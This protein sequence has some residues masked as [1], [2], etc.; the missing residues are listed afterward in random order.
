MNYEFTEENNYEDFASGRVLYNQKGT[1]SFPARLIS[2]IFLRSME[3]LKKQGI[4]G[5]YSIYDP[6]CGGA[7]GL[8][9][10]GFLHYSQISGLTASDINEGVI[11]LAERNLSL[12]TIEGMEERII[13]IKKLIEEFD[14]ASHKEAYDSA[15]RLQE[16]IRSMPHKIQTSC[17]GEDALKQK[18]SLLKSD[19]D[20][21]GHNLKFTD[22]KGRPEEIKYDMVITDLPYG[23][24]VDWTVEEGQDAVALFLENLLTKLHSHS[25]VAVSSDKNTTVKSEHYIRLGRF[26]I[27]KR[28]VVFLRPIIKD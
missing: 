5:P 19:P 13:Q 11:G 16:I 25:V 4:S 3:Y 26:N 20:I 22:T 8:T 1:T 21:L 28:Q 23:E 2:E 15:I 14:K 10:L 27:G 6:L 7:Y 24:L 12:L 17:F 18:D 9:I